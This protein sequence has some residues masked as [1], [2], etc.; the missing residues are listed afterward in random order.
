MEGAVLTDGILP[1]NKDMEEHLGGRIATQVIYMMNSHGADP[2]ILKGL[3]EAGCDVRDTYSVAE[4]FSHLRNSYARS[5]TRNLMLVAEVQAGAI[6]LLT[7]LHETYVSL[8]PTLLFDQEGNNLQ[9]AIKALQ[10][11]VRD[12]ILASESAIQRELRARVLAERTMTLEK[13]NGQ[14]VKTASATFFL[15]PI[16]ILPAHIAK[17]DA[18]FQGDI[19]SHVAHIRNTSLHLSPVEDRIFKLLFTRRNHVVSPQELLEAG[20]R[21][22]KGDP[23]EDI[24]L[25]RPHIMRLR[26]KLERH[27][28]LAHHVVNVRGNGYMFV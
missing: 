10:L 15:Q 21:K 25:L 26:D 5:G 17:A 8:P 7:L 2:A 9:P 27:P 12:Y 1:F 24:K 28:E 22:T 23:R 18:E 6:P 13:K 20:L 11:G 3:V 14:P 16:P 4:T 19:E